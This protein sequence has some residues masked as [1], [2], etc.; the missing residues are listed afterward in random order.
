M[1]VKVVEVTDIYN[2]FENISA[3]H[4]V[5]TDW[6]EI[7]EAE[8][9]KRLEEERLKKEKASAARKA[10]AAERKRKQFEKLKEEFGE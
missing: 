7:T 6:E 3:L 5:S 9:D 2:D 4:P 10:K 8:Y 1:K